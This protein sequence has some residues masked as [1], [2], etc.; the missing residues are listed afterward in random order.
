MFKGSGGEKTIA[1]EKKSVIEL[2][3]FGKAPAGLS[4]REKAKGTRKRRGASGKKKGGGRSRLN[5][6]KC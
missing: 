5:L 4:D 6:Q 2:E 3:A 1:T